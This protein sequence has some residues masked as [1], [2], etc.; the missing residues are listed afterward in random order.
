MQSWGVSPMWEDR[1]T[2]S[3]PTFSGVVGMVA[4]ALG[5]D[6]AD[7]I[8]DLRGLTFAVRADRPGH[9]M[10]DDQTAGGGTFTMDP[11][12][13]R[14]TAP[15]QFIYGA[16]RK[17]EPDEDGVLRAPWRE[18][19]RATVKM[20]KQ[21]LVDAGFIAGLTGDDAL[22]RKI[23]LALEKPRRALFLGRRSCPL[24]QIPAYGITHGDA[25][26]WP[27]T[28]PLLDDA[29]MTEPFAWVPAE[30]GQVGT[31]SVR[32]VPRGAFSGRSYRT[33]NLT[34]Q[35]VTPPSRESE[36]DDA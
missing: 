1:S 2:I 30:S 15:E 21:Y 33:L 4:N 12:T 10:T 36:D 24:A 22:V 13:G 20:T 31:S 7:D 16:A 9:V 35:R 17:P 8:S 27:W 11:L 5:R 14:Y 29:T 19:E 26:T 3:R 6:V 18:V 32:E 23:F 28:E 34:Q 25:Q